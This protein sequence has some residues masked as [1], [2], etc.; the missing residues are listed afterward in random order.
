[1][2]DIQ[3]PGRTLITKSTTATAQAS[4]RRIGHDGWI[5]LGELGRPAVVGD[6]AQINDVRLCVEA[7]ERLRIMSVSMLLPAREDV[8]EVRGNGTSRAE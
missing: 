5:N 6:E 3:M 1:M 8:A 4:G 2:A 7:V